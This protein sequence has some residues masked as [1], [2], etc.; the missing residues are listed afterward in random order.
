M[1]E[2]GWRKGQQRLIENNLGIKI[3]VSLAWEKLFQLLWGSLVWTQLKH[4]K[5]MKYLGLDSAR[6]QNFTCGA[7]KEDKF[8]LLLTKEFFEE[9]KKY[10]SQ[11]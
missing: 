6:K 4:A 2:G 10:L 11:G 1:G 9:T 8:R 7:H 5:K 3:L